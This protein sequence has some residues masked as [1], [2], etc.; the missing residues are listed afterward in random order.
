M[1]IGEAMPLI[2]AQSLRRVG[3]RSRSPGTMVR[4]LSY[5]TGTCEKLSDHRHG[6]RRCR[7]PCVLLTSNLSSAAQAEADTVNGLRHC[8]RVVLN[9]TGYTN[10]HIE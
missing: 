5:T 10:P 4:W 1:Y 9:K 3:M 8:R 6:R 7:H 2:A